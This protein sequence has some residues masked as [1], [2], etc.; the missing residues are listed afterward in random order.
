MVS[1]VEVLMVSVI[2]IV[3][4]EMGVAEGLTSM[5]FMVERLCSVFITI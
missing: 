3:Q 2:S 1:V 4:S 5:A